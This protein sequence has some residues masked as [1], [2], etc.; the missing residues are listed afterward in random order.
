MS[1][2]SIHI[3]KQARYLSLN[4]F[5]FLAGLRTLHQPKMLLFNILRFNS[6]LIFRKSSDKYIDSTFNSLDVILI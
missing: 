4:A 2:L 1:V 5:D 3:F 6:Q